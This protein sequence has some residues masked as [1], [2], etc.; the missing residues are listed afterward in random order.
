VIPP[1]TAQRVWPVMKLPGKT[2]MPWKNQTAP[3]NIKIT[4]N[5]RSTRLM[6]I[7]ARR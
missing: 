6:M 4:L 3:I 7:N 2:L 5:T 1:I